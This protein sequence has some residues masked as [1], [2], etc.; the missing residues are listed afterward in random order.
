LGGEATDRLDQVYTHQASW[1]Q[2]LTSRSGMEG[3]SD[4]HW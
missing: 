4:L 1:C 3:W 2:D